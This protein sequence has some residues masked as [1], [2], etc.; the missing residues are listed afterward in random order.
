MDREQLL[1]EAKRR[2]PI[3]CTFYPVV[4]ADGELIISRITTQKQECYLYEDNEGNTWVIGTHNIRHPNGK[5]AKVISYPHTITK[6][7]KSKILQL[8]KDI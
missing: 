3:G 2:F 7:Q 5:W 6:E 4:T 1:K 8:I